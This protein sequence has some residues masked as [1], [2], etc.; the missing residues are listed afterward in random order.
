MTPVERDAAGQRAHALRRQ[1]E[2]LTWQH[3]DAPSFDPKSATAQQLA[4]LHGELRAAEAEQREPVGPAP[5]DEGR[6]FLGRETSGLTAEV[7]PRMSHVPTGIAHLLDA[8][9][10]LVSV[11]ITNHRRT[12]ARVR[13]A[14]SVTGYSA[15]AVDTV[16]V[17]RDETTEVNLFPVFFPER[18]RPLDELTRASLKVDIDDLDGK[19]ET[20]RTYPLWLLARTSAVNGFIDATTNAWT[21]LTHYYGAWVTPA[22]AP[23]RELLHAAAEAHPRKALV[24][25]Q[26]DAPGVEAQ[27]AAIFAAVAE[28]GLSYVTSSLCH[29]TWDGRL[30]QRVRLPSEAL[31]HRTAN[32]L[33]GTLLMASLLEAASLNPG[34]VFIPMHALL[35][36]EKEAGSGN[37][38]Y[39]ETTLIGGKDFSAALR[40]G[41]ERAESHLAM[42]A[43]LDDGRFFVRHSVFELR[44]T[45][46]IWP[47]E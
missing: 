12:P 4:R 36:W 42:H 13:I 20:Q 6:R 33:D 14:A 41:R 22:A 44:A 5:G 7:L 32:C 35:A 9:T 3:F 26:T 29:G 37:W 23:V 1:I 46:G 25:Y 43:L 17:P 47:M 16:E 8:T 19:K 18:L 27:V 2:T 31:A 21:D 40:K 10:P 30:G 15:D 45:R 11:R 39:L 38:D 34:L 24:G 28:R